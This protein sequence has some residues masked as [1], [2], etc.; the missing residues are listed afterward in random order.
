MYNPI[1]VQTRRPGQMRHSS[2][3][4]R[5]GSGQIRHRSGQIRHALDRNV[6]A[7]DSV[8]T[9]VKSFRGMLV[10]DNKCSYSHRS[11]KRILF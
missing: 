2:G 8:I 1:K 4:I 5:H 11:L 6:I 9:V 7:L 10:T 3:Q